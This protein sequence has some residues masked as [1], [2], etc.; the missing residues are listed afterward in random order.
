MKYSKDEILE[1][2]LNTIYLGENYYG[3]QVAAQGYFGKDLGDLTIRE[4]AILAGTTNNPYYYNPRRN[5]YT[6]KS[7]D[8]DYAEVTNNRSSVLPA[9]R[10]PSR[11]PAPPHT[12]HG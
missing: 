5:L 10:S 11:D 4:C 12:V 3:V 8:K 1:C 6:R 7:E 9:A 2:Y